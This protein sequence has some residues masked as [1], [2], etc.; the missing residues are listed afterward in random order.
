MTFTL[1]ANWKMNTLWPQAAGLARDLGALHRA[2]KAQGTV[3]ICPPFPWLLPLK[4]VL[5]SF[6]H[7]STGAQ[8]CSDQPEGAFTGEVSAAML[9]ASGCTHVLVGHS[10]RRQRLHDDAFI[11]GKI[12][13]A[14]A[15]GLVPVLCVG[16]PRADGS[17]EETARILEH[18]ITSALADSPLTAR[19]MIAWEPVWAIGSGQTPDPGQMAR[20]LDTLRAIALK[21]GRP[22]PP[23]LYGGSVQGKTARSARPLCDGFLVGGAS[24]DPEKFRPILDAL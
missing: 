3:V 4:D 24:L 5:E 10:E 22:V 7:I 15:S 17:P 2:S 8:D 18:Q 20:T 16:E 23:L 12:R 11:P 13:Q 14:L 6:P 1:I 19:L 21:A 9:R